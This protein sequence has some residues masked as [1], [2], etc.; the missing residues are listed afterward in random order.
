MIHNAAKWAFSAVSGLRIVCLSWIGDKQEGFEGGG[1]EDCLEVDW[2]FGIIAQKLKNIDL[3]SFE[4]LE[5]E[6]SLIEIQSQSLLVMT[7]ST[8]RVRLG[9]HG[10]KKIISTISDYLYTFYHLILGLI[11]SDLHFDIWFAMI[12]SK[13]LKLWSGLWWELVLI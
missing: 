6:L 4:A 8:I 12:G 7:R 1:E 9:F 3:P 13:L 2:M 10:W 5:S 11:C